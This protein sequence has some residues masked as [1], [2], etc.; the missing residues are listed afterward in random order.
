M[1]NIIKT[2]SLS[3]IAMIFVGTANAAIVPVHEYNTS[4]T[5]KTNNPNQIN[6]KCSQYGCLD[7]KPQG[8][9][10]SPDNGKY[11]VN[12]DAT[13]YCNCGCSS[14][15]KYTCEA[16]F[17]PSGTACVENGVSLYKSCECGDGYEEVTDHNLDSN[18]FNF[19]LA[20]MDDGKKCVTKETDWTCKGSY[21][22]LFTDASSA[23]DDIVEASAPNNGKISFKCKHEAKAGSFGSLAPVYYGHISKS[24][25]SASSN[26]CLNPQEIKY[27]EDGQCVKGTSI[28]N[29]AKCVST[30]TRQVQWYGTFIEPYTF[31]TECNTSDTECGSVSS[32]CVAQDHSSVKTR[33][34]SGLTCYFANGCKNEVKSGHMC[35]GNYSDHSSSPLSYFNYERESEKGYECLKVNSGCS[36]SGYSAA[37]VG[38]GTGITDSIKDT[39]KNVVDGACTDVKTYTIQVV[40]GTST[41]NK[42]FYICRT[43]SGCK[44]SCNYCDTSCDGVWG[45]KLGWFF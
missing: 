2:L 14:E 31:Y 19:T 36:A 33:D 13:C 6:F 7:S 21:K 44:T 39:A 11:Y 16:P 32:D 27:C 30:E 41:S 4:I 15:Y 22:N 24:T 23:K 34:G 28:T 40:E 35:A 3:C 8:T 18:I 17:K 9:V 42:P 26:L 25:L 37:D 12:I 20:E 10:C 5:G 38:F 1:T 43:P 29:P 45:G